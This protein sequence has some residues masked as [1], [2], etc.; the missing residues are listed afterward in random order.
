MPGYTLLDASTHTGTQ[1]ESV[2]VSGADA[3]GDLLVRVASAG[4]R[5]STLPYTLRYLYVDEP[6]EQHCPAF[7][8]SHSAEYVLPAIVPPVLL[9]GTNTIFLVDTTRMI[10]EYGYLPNPDDILQ[11]PID[12]GTWILNALANLDGQFGLRTA[13]IPVTG[14][15]LL[16]GHP[17]QPVIDARAALDA[18]PCSVRA[19]NRMANAVRDLLGTFL[20]PDIQASLKNVVIVGGDDQIPFHRVPGATFDVR[21][22]WN[23]SALRLPAA[24][25]GNCAASPCDRQ[26]T[27]LSAAAAGDF[28]VTDDPYG[29]R[30]PAKVLDRDLYVPDVALGRL[31][32][33]PQD[34]RA[35][36]LTYLERGGVL[37]AD[38][39]LSTGYG[40]WDEVPP[41]IAAAVAD[42]VTGA[43]NK[44]LTGE[45]SKANLKAALGFD[46]GIEPTGAEDRVHQRPHDRVR[47]APGNSRGG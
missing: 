34:I 8:P 10:Q 24:R 16:G 45:W 21:E 19:A 28:I 39:A 42:R 9:P 44:T 27:P 33:S 13:V 7:T 26:A 37:S 30:M 12:A 17:T 25:S 41:A 6:P 29:D 11:L 43:N 4:D 15:D 46:T 20:T 40:A 2:S 3:G 32:E 5:V 38:T 23:E 35:A 1:D 14:L 36:V 31:V 22:E 47:P 18:D